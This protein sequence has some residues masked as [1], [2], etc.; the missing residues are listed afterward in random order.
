LLVILITALPRLSVSTLKSKSLRILDLDKPILWWSAC[1][2]SL[3]V[4]FERLVPAADVNSIAAFIGWLRADCILISPS[5]SAWRLEEA[6]IKNR[7]AAIA[8][9]LYMP[10]SPFVVLAIDYK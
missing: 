3:T 10:E 8:D 4:T 5:P 9:F 7:A 6:V 1:E 2:A